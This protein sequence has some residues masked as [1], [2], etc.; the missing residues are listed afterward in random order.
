MTN[1]RPSSPPSATRPG[2]RSSTCCSRGRSPSASSPRCCR[3]A[4]RRS[5]STSRC[6]RRS[7]SWWTG[8]RGPG[9]STAWTRP[10]WPRSAPT[11]TG[12]GRRPWSRS[13]STPKSRPS[14]A[15]TQG[16]GPMT[17][18]TINPVRVSVSVGLDQ[19][20]CFEVFTDEMTSWWPAGHHIGEA[21]IEEVV[22]E[23]FVG[24]RWYTRHTDGSETET[25]V[26]TAYDAAER[27]HRHLADRCRLGLPR[28]PGHHDRGAV[29][30][31]RRRPHPGRARAPRP[32]GVRRRRGPD[33]G[34]LR[35]PGR[36][37]RHARALRR[38]R[39]AR[40]DAT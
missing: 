36:L 40:P 1:A 37:G 28:R 3:S 9:G 6:S 4:G 26:V 5:P 14:A 15:P 38:G 18:Q 20:R 33:A 12:S 27:L 8:R 13:P 2:R 24:G 39:R 29:H 7:G 16:E 35:G 11:S 34:D 30:A 25:G 17:Q 32:R 21:P 31:D 23:P 10:D 22:I 19:Q